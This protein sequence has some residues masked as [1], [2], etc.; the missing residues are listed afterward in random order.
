MKTSR[1]VILLIVLTVF[2]VI[3]ALSISPYRKLQLKG[4]ANRFASDIR[5]CQQYAMQKNSCYLMQFDKKHHGYTVKRVKDALVVDIKDPFKK[6]EPFKVD[7]YTG[8]TKGIKIKDINFNGGNELRFSPR[9]VPMDKRD[10]P[11]ASNGSVT[12]ENASGT[13]SIIVSPDT[14]RVAQS[15]DK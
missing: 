1:A 12:L 10:V 9:G 6:N 2:V 13:V 3:I 4:A 11:L 7:F 14:G 8:S 15:F 5:I